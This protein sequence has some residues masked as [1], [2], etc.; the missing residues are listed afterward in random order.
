MNKGVT[1]K[2]IHDLAVGILARDLQEISNWD[3]MSVPST[4]QIEWMKLVAGIA[5]STE[6]QAPLPLWLTNGDS[7]PVTGTVS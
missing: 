4:D 6:P 5:R 7:P 1:M 2:D 3:P